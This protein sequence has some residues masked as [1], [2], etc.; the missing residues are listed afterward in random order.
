[1]EFAASVAGKPDGV[2]VVDIPV[3]ADVPVN[4]NAMNQ[5]EILFEF[6]EIPY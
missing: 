3:D 4:D 1:M 5:D 2:P 6:N